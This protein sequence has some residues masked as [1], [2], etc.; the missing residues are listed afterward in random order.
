MISA[1]SNPKPNF[2]I[3]VPPSSSNPQV[4]PGGNPFQ[5]RI[6]FTQSIQVMEL[7]LIVTS[8]VITFAAQVGTTVLNSTVVPLPDGTYD[9]VIVVP[10]SLTA[11][12][13]TQVLLRIVPTATTN[14]TGFSIQG[15]TSK[16]GILKR[17]ISYLRWINVFG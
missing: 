13:V 10:P 11:T 12:A 2:Q 5:P 17:I 8:P 9:Y 15:C 1:V 16:C 3:G 7:D 4:L 14:I 6:T